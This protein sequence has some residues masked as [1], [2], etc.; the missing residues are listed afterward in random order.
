MANG[1]RSL[2]PAEEHALRAELEGVLVVSDHARIV[3]ASFVNDGVMVV[4]LA[5]LTSDGEAAKRQIS[6]LIADL[7]LDASAEEK[8]EIRASAQ[9]LR[10]AVEGERP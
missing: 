1:K 7:W 6:D 8:E 4:D 10:A 5:A 2:T 3:A 9:R